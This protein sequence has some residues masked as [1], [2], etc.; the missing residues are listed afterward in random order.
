MTASRTG[1]VFGK[2]ELIKQ[3]TAIY[4]IQ[5]S[6]PFI[7]VALTQ[8]SHGFLS[9]QMPNLLPPRQ[10]SSCFMGDHSSAT[11]FKVGDSVTVVEDVM[12]AG[13]NLK[14]LTGKVIET[15]EKCDVDPT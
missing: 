13:R 8:Y 7:L 4:M 2:K 10:S 9:K 6:I 14:G 1:S 11:V 3:I 12:K 15:W 5:L